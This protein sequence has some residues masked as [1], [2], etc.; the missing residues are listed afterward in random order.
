M[1][2]GTPDLVNISCRTW[3]MRHL[4]LSG[5]VNVINRGFIIINHNED[6]VIF[7]VLVTFDREICNK[8]LV[9]YETD[10]PNMPKRS[11]YR[12]KNL[13]MATLNLS[14]S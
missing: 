7:E 6:L 14:H 3:A 4:Q 10:L 13:L 9:N 11:T 1:K 5:Y 2:S 8:L 12:P